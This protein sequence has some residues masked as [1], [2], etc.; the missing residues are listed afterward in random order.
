MKKP[1][2]IDPHYTGCAERRVEKKGRAQVHAHGLEEGPGERLQE[3]R[4]PQ[5]HFVAGG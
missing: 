4:V 2:Q 1:L 5:L 3:G